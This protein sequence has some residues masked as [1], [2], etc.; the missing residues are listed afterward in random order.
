L[1]A[2]AATAAVER[3][4]AAWARA[5]EEAAASRVAAAVAKKAGA[6]VGRALAEAVRWRRRR[7]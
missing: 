3:V 2:K 4:V 5:E 6:V 1:H 7:V